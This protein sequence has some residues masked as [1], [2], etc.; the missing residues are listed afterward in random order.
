[1]DASRGEAVEAAAA[2]DPA[3]AEGGGIAAV[4]GTG[5]RAAVTRNRATTDVGRTMNLLY[6]TQ[7]RF[8]LGDHLP[9]I[10]EAEGEKAGGRKLFQ[11][12]T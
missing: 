9:F 2:S 10:A 4:R 12:R 8:R 5:T 11:G 3:A 7:I 6:P 1:M